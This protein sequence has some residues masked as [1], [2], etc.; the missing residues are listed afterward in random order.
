M[1][2]WAFACMTLA[3][4]CAGTQQP[5]SPMT[6]ASHKRTAACV[7][8]DHQPV[9]IAY[10]DAP[11]GSTVSFATDG[12]AEALRERVEE[13][14]EFHNS[15]LRQN[16]MHDLTAV[17]HRA[18][19][20][21]AERGAKLT[22]TASANNDEDALRKSVQQEVEQLKAHGCIASQEAL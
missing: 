5:T 14:A 3:L 7:S 18:E 2:K 21:P 22:L 17:P 15:D 1:T 6:G 12:S 13:L 9:E 8:Q 20:E 16:E 4:G 10:R 11:G 19:F